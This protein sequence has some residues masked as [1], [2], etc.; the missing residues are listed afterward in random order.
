MEIRIVVTGRSYHSAATLPETLQLP[1]GATLDDALRVVN[2]SLADGAALPDSCL[3]A[4]D[5]RHVGTVASH[6]EVSL[7]DG[8]EV[9]LIAPVAGG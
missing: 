5:S 9:V 2:E 1:E 3:V 6:A 4:V 8:Q 7:S